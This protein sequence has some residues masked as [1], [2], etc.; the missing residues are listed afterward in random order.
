MLPVNGIGRARGRMSLVKSALISTV[1]LTAVLLIS[2]D[3]AGAQQAPAQDGQLRPVDVSAPRQRPQQATRPAPP[4]RPV[5]RPLRQPQPV[6]QPAPVPVQTAPMPTQFPG[7]P[8]MSGLD[9]RQTSPLNGS[10]VTQIGTRLGIPVR[11]IPATVD[12]VTQDIMREQGY[13]TTAEA[14]AGAPGV[15]AIDVAGAPANFQIRGF[16]FG[17]VN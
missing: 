6:A 14:A 1:S 5:Q 8:L 15:L 13:R 17:E 2:A 16:T 12:V 3:P 4:A 11:E 9:G 7:V 10:S